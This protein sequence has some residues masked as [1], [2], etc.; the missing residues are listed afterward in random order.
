MMSRSK[1][2]VDNPKLFLVLRIILGGIFLIAGIIKALNPDGS[3]SFVVS[4]N[5]LP[6]TLAWLYGYLLP[7]VEIAIGCTLLL[8]PLPRVEPHGFISQ[9]FTIA[10]DLRQGRRPRTG[11]G[12]MHFALVLL[13]VLPIISCGSG[14][15][16]KS[17]VVRSENQSDYGSPYK[18]TL[19]TCDDGYFLFGVITD[20]F[21]I[22]NDIY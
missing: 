4:Y 16:D 2:L 1:R 10:W 14:E 22:D 12:I 13:L 7:W 18:V 17:N 20:T 6:Y 19:N 11:I 15:D 3:V 21:N 8:G 9:L 5:I